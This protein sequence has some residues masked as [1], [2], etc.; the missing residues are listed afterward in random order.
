MLDARRR[1]FITLLGGAAVVWPLVAYAQQPAMPVIGF[2]NGAN[3]QAYARPM[4]AFHRGLSE[5]GYIDGRNVAIEFRWADGHYDR[6]PAMAADLVRR[7]VAAIAASG[8]AVFAAK[9]ATTTTPIVFT[10]GYDPIELG[11]VTSLNQPGGN[12]TGVSLLGAELGPKRLQ[13]LH[14][15]LP[16]ATTV[17]VLVNPANRGTTATLRILQEAANK[18]GLQIHVLHASTEHEIDAAFATLAQRQ[19]GALVIGSDGF[20]NSRSAHLA[21]L[22]VRHALPT[23]FQYADFAAA[24]GLMSY[25]GSLTDAYLRAGNYTGRILAG[26]KPSELPIQQSTKVELIINLK[27]AKAL[28]LAIPLPLIGRADELIE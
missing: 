19:I 21:A 8:P 1:G 3:P 13:L 20:F 18:I 16:A 26:A 5:A 25:G 10:T 12:L 2:L 23:I 11:I 15:L 17:A 27:T 24:G 28:G 14:E 22:T 4:A 7:Q 9:A 6:F